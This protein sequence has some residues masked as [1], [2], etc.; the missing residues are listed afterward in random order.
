MKPR[1]RTDVRRSQVDPY[2]P[3]LQLQVTEITPL[4]LHKI[5]EQKALTADDSEDELIKAS[6]GMTSK[7]ISSH[8]NRRKFNP[9]KVSRQATLPELPSSLNSV[10]WLCKRFTLPTSPHF[11]DRIY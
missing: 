11:M 9:P 1:Q 5:V 7:L 2:S 10:R 6:P 3:L 4:L 8:L